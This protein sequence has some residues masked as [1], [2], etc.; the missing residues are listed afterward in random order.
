MIGYL[1]DIHPKTERQFETQKWLAGFDKTGLYGRWM[2]A[3]SLD[4]RNR[5]LRKRYNLRWNAIRYPWI[6][7]VT[8]QGEAYI[9]GTTAYR[10]AHNLSKLYK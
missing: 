1:F 6:S 2:Q 3:R 8:S 5:R 9:Q 10:V 4:E 7:G